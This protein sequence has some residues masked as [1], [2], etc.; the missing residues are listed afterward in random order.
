MSACTCN[1]PTSLMDTKEVEYYGGVKATMGKHFSF[2]A[3]AAYISYNNMP[4]FVN[5]TGDGKNFKVVNESKMSSFLIHGDMNFVSQDKF[6]LTTAADINTYAGLHTNDEAWHLI[7][8]QL[9]SSFRWHAFKQVLIKGDLL[10]FSKVPALVGASTKK[11]LKGGTDLSAGAEFKITNMFSAWVD[12][13]N[14]LNSK[15][16]RW[17]NYP[18]YGLN[19]LGGVIVHF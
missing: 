5:N 17:N 16:T 18:V 7:P 3:K 4:L 9:T 2:N 15:Y 19:V 10:A 13:N 6:T 11:I 8:I 12:L 1:V 14:L